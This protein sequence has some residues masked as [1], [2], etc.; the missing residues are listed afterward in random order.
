MGTNDWQTIS[1]T[2]TTTSSG[3]WTRPSVDLSGYAGQSVK[4][5][6]L[7]SAVDVNDGFGNQPETSAGWYID[8]VRLLHDFALLLLDSPV[9]L[10]Q[11]TACVS[12]GIAAGSPPSSVSF[13]LEAPAGHLGNLSL[14]TSGCWSGTLT[15]QSG[16]H[17]LV[18]LQNSCPHALTGVQ[19]I[20]S[21]CYTAISPKSA[22]VPLAVSNLAVT[23]QDASLPIGHASGSRTVVIANES[24]LEPWLD[25]T[26]KRM[27][28]TFGKANTGYVIH[29]STNATEARPWQPAWTNLIHF[30]SRPVG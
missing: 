25:S 13:T 22:F 18:T 10:T 4:V 23:N 1:P 14:N 2:Y 8:E 7:F 12:L 9:V 20:G 17:W 11:N 21:I 30:T 16:N 5:G 28:T 29:Q 19:N 27:V 24:L 3:V 26:Q 15:P 6:F